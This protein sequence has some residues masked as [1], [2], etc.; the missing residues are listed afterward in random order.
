MDWSFTFLSKWTWFDSNFLSQKEC[1]LKK[2]QRNSWI[3]WWLL[4]KNYR[5]LWTWGWLHI[6]YYWIRIHLYT[7]PSNNAAWV[8]NWKMKK[9]I[10]IQI[11]AVTV[12]EYAI[13]TWSP[14]NGWIRVW[15]FYSQMIDHKAAIEK[16]RNSKPFL[17][18]IVQIICSWNLA[19][20]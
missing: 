2:F 6:P 20:Q 15:Y 16:K 1:F 18:S 14:K 12:L 11:R 3:F 8:W 7:F 9:T 13:F 17:R 4:L 10:I 19:S 5:L